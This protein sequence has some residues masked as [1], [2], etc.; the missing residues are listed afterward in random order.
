VAIIFPGL[1]N[2]FAAVILVMY[3]EPRERVCWLQM[4]FPRLGSWQRSPK[5]H[6]WIWGTTSR[7]G[8]REKGRKGRKK[9]RDRREGRKYPP[10]W[11]YVYGVVGGLEAASDLSLLF[12]GVF[13]PRGR[14]HVN[15]SYCCS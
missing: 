2:T 5:S 9:E 14:T 6:S 7:R 12:S 1:Q 15:E 10:K 8:K 3:L 11:I 13:G 4:S